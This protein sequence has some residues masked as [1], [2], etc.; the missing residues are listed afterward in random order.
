MDIREAMTSRHSVRNYKDLP[1]EAAFTEKLAEEIKACNEESGLNIQMILND[2]ACFDTLIAHY[3]KFRHADNY[4]ALVGKKDFGDLF[5]RCGYYGE[6]IVLF[7]QTLGLRS[8]WVAGS[9]RKGKCAAEIKPDEKLVCVI[10]FGYGETDGVKHR[11]KSYEKVCDVKKEDMPGWFK[12][13]LKAALLAPTAINQQQFF[14]TLEGE[15]AVIR[16][17]MGP[18]SKIDLGIVKYHFE[19]A[20]GRHCRS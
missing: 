16:A 10:S 13:G 9:Y 19:A 6:R 20:S 8:C 15:E 2:P 18:Y 12:N 5:E 4:I 11:S 7:M 3:G 1:I 14:I 17:K